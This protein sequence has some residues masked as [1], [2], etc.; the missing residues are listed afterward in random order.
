MRPSIINTLS[1][2]S[3]PNQVVAIETGNRIDKTTIQT[4]DDGFGDVAIAGQIKSDFS[5]IL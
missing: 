1:Y 5:G 4:F 3:R 2:A